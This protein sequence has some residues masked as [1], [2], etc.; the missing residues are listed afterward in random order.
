MF[1]NII[2]DLDGTIIDSYPAIGRAYAAALQE[3]GCAV[4]HAEIDALAC[5]SLNLCTQTLAER[6]GLEPEVLEEALNR[7]YAA[8]APAEQPPLPGV[9]AVLQAV[10][11]RG[12]KNVL[13]THRDRAGALA[14]LQAHG[15][16][17]Y[18]A[19]ILGGDDGFPR[20]PDPAVFN[21]ALARWG[22]DPGE[23]LAVGDRA[24]DIQ[25][26]Q[27][28]GLAALLYGTGLP[29]I[30]PDYTLRDY[31]ALLKLLAV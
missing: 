19:G 24:I 1:R 13:V 30:Q 5:V 3:L 18:F 28:A 25:G 16:L 7:H 12:G 29:G 17:A 2:W 15:L 21:A 22:L 11:A 14:L 20:K 26:A 4:P 8:A 27:A 31:S 6:C 10:A 23:T 9:A